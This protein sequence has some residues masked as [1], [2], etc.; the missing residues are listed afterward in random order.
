MTLCHSAVCA[1]QDSGS[2]DTLSSRKLMSELSAEAVTV[3]QPR[4]L[5]LST[6]HHS[7][8]LRPLH[9]EDEPLMSPAP[10]SPQ[11]PS[12]A[13]SDALG[14][15]AMD[16]VLCGM[17][18]SSAAHHTAQS[19]SSSLSLRGLLSRHAFT[20]HNEAGAAGSAGFV[21]GAKEVLCEPGLLSSFDG[22]VGVAAPLRT[23]AGGRA[24][25]FGAADANTSL[26][27]AHAKGGDLYS[28]ALSPSPHRATFD[29]IQAGRCRTV[30]LIHLSLLSI[31]I[32]LLLV[33]IMIGKWWTLTWQ[34]M[35]SLVL[36]APHQA[37]VPGSS[38]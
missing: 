12:A 25:A 22:S 6:D 20:L 26:D 35:P 18:M 2:E 15:A 36:W 23:L 24:A 3:K 29:G 16:G 34:T 27:T 38:A 32:H 17:S 5:F 14:P 10:V 8:L 31:M 30:Q 9:D 13:H 1:V 7:G 4:S 21:A 33:S 19:S 28:V 11:P 37:V